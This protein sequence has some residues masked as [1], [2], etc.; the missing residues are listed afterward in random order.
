MSFKVDLIHIRNK[1][2]NIW[3]F[4]SKN[5]S[6]PHSVI[7][8]FEITR[9]KSIFTKQMLKHISILK[10]DYIAAFKFLNRL[11]LRTLQSV[12]DPPLGHFLSLLTNLSTET[13]NIVA[14]VLE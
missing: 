10:I 7:L 4:I 11:S 12:A 6:C 2:P 5:Y 8:L 3:L 14:E 9:Q 1:Y 13:S